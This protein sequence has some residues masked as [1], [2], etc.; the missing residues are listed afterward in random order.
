LSSI[1][2]AYRTLKTTSE[3][4]FKDKGSKF[5]AIAV[6]I[7]S[8]EEAKEALEDIRKKYHDARHHCYAWAL[9]VNRELYRANDDGEPSNSAGKPILGRLESHDLTQLLIVVVRYFGGVKL[10]VGGLINAYRSAAEDAIL[11]GKIVKRKQKMHFTVFFEYPQ[12]NDIMQVVKNSKLA[13]I[14]QDFALSCKIK[15]TCPNA[16]YSQVKDVFLAI[17]NVEI[18]EVRVE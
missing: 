17:E 18:E 7:R 4:I 11:N 9:G 3:G 14:D 1:K 13:Q 16:D 10:G 5:I 6:P 2:D 15:L 8:E 12:M